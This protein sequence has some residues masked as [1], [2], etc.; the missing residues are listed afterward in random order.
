M[1]FFD[2]DLDKVVWYANLRITP[3]ALDNQEL[4]NE[5]IL[6]VLSKYPNSS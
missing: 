4:V 1:R 5:L 6:K 3:S 2:E